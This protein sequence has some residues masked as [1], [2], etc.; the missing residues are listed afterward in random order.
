V[1]HWLSLYVHKT[2][3]NQNSLNQSAI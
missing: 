3:I 2:T 1:W